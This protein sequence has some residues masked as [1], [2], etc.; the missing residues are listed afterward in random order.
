MMQALGI[1][2]SISIPVSV[3][4]EQVA[5]VL[6]LFGACPNQFETQRMQQFARSLQHRWEQMWMRCCFPRGSAVTEEQSC[7]LRDRLFSDGLRMYVQPIVNLRT[8]KLLEVEALVR[9][10]DTDGIIIEP[11]SFLS[12]LG[13]NELDRLFHMGL[14]ESLSLLQQWQ[15]DGQV[16]N[17][18]VNM[19]PTYLLNEDGPLWVES[20]LQRY[21]IRPE[22]LTVELLETQMIDPTLQDIAIQKFKA[23]GVKIAIDDLGSGYSNLLRLSSLPFDIIKVDQGLLRNI[24]TAPLQTFSMVKSVLDMGVDFHELVIVEGLEDDDMI[25]AIYHLGCRYGQG[26][27]ISPPMSPE[28]FTKWY[29]DYR[30]K[31]HSCN[32]VRELMSDLGVLAYHWMST[33]GGQSASQHALQHSLITHWLVAQGLEGSEV[34]QW[35]EQC[36]YGDD[37]AG[38]SS[39]FIDWLVERIARTNKDRL[40]LVEPQPEGE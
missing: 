10:Q 40:P 3:E 11:G 32:Y 29:A 9:I 31:A 12:L 22:Q 28:H 18:A 14:E 6:T 17:L 37:P 1:S 30:V 23:I 13:Q 34:A 5:V 15:N 35:H 24:R 19:P 2:S 20:A 36:H 4:E 38:A 8:G 7:H 33:R 26:Y 39:K 16:I 21:N 27:G 25:E